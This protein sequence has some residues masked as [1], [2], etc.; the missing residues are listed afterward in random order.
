LQASLHGSR[1]IA[2][3]SPELRAKVRI[4]NETI[5]IIWGKNDEECRFSLF[6]P[7]LM[8]ILDVVGDDSF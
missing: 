8:G 6:Y 1:L 7:I 4:K 5:R 2:A 3:F